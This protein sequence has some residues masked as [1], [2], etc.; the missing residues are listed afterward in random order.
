MIRLLERVNS[1]YSRYETRMINKYIDSISVK[2][3]TLH[4]VKNVGRYVFDY[5][6]YNYQYKDSLLN[7][8][9]AAFDNANHEYSICI[10]RYSGIKQK[11]LRPR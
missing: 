8:D 11:A 9:K 6:Y 10:I 3:S 2:K 5:M 1:Q 7:A 4:K